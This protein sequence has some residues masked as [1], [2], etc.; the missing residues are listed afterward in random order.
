MNNMVVT[1]SRNRNPK[2][3]KIKTRNPEKK[4]YY[5]YQD[6][7]PKSRDHSRNSR[8]VPPSTQTAVLVSTV[9]DPIDLQVNID[10]RGY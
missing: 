1:K 8:S 9:E 3:G 4:E 5:N 6:S 10:D 7:G 2:T